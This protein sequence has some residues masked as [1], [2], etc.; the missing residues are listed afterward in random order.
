MTEPEN[1]VARGGSGTEEAYVA[2]QATQ[3]RVRY[4][5]MDR[6]LRGNVDYQK[7][8]PLFFLAHS[9]SWFDFYAQRYNID[10]VMMMT[11]Q[12]LSR[13][14]G[15]ENVASRCFP[16]TYALFMVNSAGEQFLARKYDGYM[17]ISKETKTAVGSSKEFHIDV[18]DF[19][20]P[21]EPRLIAASVPITDPNPWEARRRLGHVM[22]NI[23]LYLDWL[24][25][26]GRLDRDRH[27][28]HGKFPV[29]DQEYLQR[30]DFLRREGPRLER[31]IEEIV[32]GLHLALA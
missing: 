31:V 10:E 22:E 19:S 7:E 27:M 24:K 14:E 28:V 4:D 26:E 29:S 16:D 5:E 23:S 6:V 3:T 17:I 21:G 30:L 25:L 2:K 18:Y 9:R 20:F 12:H 11:T 15:I 32:P 1:A 8:L 13:H